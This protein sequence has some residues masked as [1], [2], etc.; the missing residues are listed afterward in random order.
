MMRGDVEARGAPVQL[1]FGGKR[2]I[3]VSEARL[4]QMRR[5]AQTIRREPFTKRAWAE[6]LYFCLSVPLT[7]IGIAFIAVTMF[8]GIALAITFIGIL[9]IAGGLRGVRGFGGFHRALARNFLDEHI[10]E[11]APFVA[12]P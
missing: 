6:L 5:I 1:Q 10:E 7:A 8:L 2:V 3:T 9:I 12:R 11:P 4:E